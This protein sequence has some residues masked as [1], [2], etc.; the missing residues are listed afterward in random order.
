MKIVHVWLSDMQPIG[1]LNTLICLISRLH[2]KCF[3]SLAD[4]SEPFM[5]PDLLVNFHLQC[6]ETEK[7]A[8]Q[9][10]YPFKWPIQKPQW[11]IYTAGQ[12]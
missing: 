5:L 9:R 3:Q 1:N 2:E 8:V 6:T 7:R 10:I 12:P 4:R 11:P